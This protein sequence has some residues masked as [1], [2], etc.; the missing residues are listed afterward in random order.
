MSVDGK[1]ATLG[2]IVAMRLTWSAVHSSILTD[3]PVI[4]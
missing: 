2:D 3:V 1:I 4:K